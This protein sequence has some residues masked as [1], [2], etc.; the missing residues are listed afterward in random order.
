MST[1]LRV[2]VN[3]DGYTLNDVYVDHPNF[4]GLNMGINGIYA[5][6]SPGVTNKYTMSGT[7]GL[8]NPVLLAMTTG[9]FS[10]NDSRNAA[11]YSP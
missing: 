4:Q 8:V 1:R 11:N 10:P 3:I 5:E 6:V 9:I 7:T 2:S